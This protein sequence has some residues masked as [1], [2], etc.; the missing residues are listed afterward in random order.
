MKSIRNPPT[1]NHKTI[2]FIVDFFHIGG[3]CAIASEYTQLLMRRGYRVIVLGLQGD[4]HRYPSYFTE[5]FRGAR[6]FIIPNESWEEIHKNLFTKVQF[7]LRFF[8]QFIIYTKRILI[9]YPVDAIHFN[10]SWS[11]LAILLCVRRVFKIPRVTIFY[12]DLALEY[13]A[14][15]PSENF[16]KNFIHRL[17]A[18][19]Y[20]LIQKV[21]FHLSSKVI[22]FGTYSLSLL[23]RYN[24]SSLKTRVIPAFIHDPPGRLI[25]KK[26]HAPF[27]VVSIARFEKRK[28]HSVLLQAAKNILNTGR[29]IHVTLSGPMTGDIGPV[30]QTYEQLTLLSHVTIFH[31][32]L[33]KQ[34]INL[35]RSGDVFIMS[36]T[37]LE[38]FGITVI[39]SLAL[40]VPV[41]CFPNGGAPEILHRV[42]R[43]LIAKTNSVQALSSRIIWL[44]S[45]SNSEYNQLRQRCVDAVRRYYSDTSVQQ[46]V[47]SL[48]EQ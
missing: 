15:N 24:V 9:E 12:N 25:P 11:A 33:G 8:Y 3:V 6:M 41:V 7:R 10:L 37:S 38:F 5:Y 31:A 21:V 18:H 14:N 42:D 34:K 16:F 2:L 43:H 48:Y 29:S 45:I 36:S 4:A 35:M 22:V 30:L 17:K 46:Q 26:R 19:V 47:L 1:V 23:R 40:G 27:H 44:M 28:G 32:T 20:Y 13:L 39:E